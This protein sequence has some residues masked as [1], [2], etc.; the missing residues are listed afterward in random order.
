MNDFYKKIRVKK[1]LLIWGIILFVFFICLGLIMYDSEKNAEF[2]QMSISLDEETYAKLNVKLLET[3]FAIESVDNEKRY[4]YL[5]YDENTHPYVV[6]LTPDVLNKLKSIQDYTMSNEEM[7]EPDAVTIKGKVENID[8]EAF[9]ALYEYINDGEEESDKITITELK[10]AVGLNY[11][12][13]SYDNNTEAV[14]Y[15]I[16]FGI[17]SSIGLIM[18][19]IYFVR[20]NNY[21]KTM[22]DYGNII[23]KIKD[24]FESGKA[25]YNKTSGVFLTD[26]YLIATNSGLKLIDLNDIVWIYPVKQKNNGIT[27][28]E[29]IYVITS[30]K[31]SNIVATFTSMGKKNKASFDELYQDIINKVPNALVGYTNENKMKVKELYKN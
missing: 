11:L 1:G 18:I 2:V 23:D 27:F 10:K 14:T 6:M 17:F 28:S 13:T 5:A 25:I 15:L 31:K 22:K 20:K 19:V 29:S 12:D 9:D 16:I 21:K 24:E 4:Y 7:D 26:N 30:D 3:E 8:D